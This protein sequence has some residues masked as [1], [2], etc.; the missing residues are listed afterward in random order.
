[1]SEATDNVTVYIDEECG[2]RQWIWRT[3]MTRTSLVAWWGSQESILPYSADL[4]KLPGEVLPAGYSG[5]FGLADTGVVQLREQA[6]GSFIP[7]SGE[8]IPFERLRS[9]FNAHLHS[10]DDS[11]LWRGGP[12]EERWTHKGYVSCESRT[13]SKQP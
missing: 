5:D 12:T 2:Y 13:E 10:E 9:G 6:D 3:G 11:L 8:I 4:M 1:M 7:L